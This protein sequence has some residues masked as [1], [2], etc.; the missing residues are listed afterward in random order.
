MWL[1]EAVYSQLIIHELYECY[2]K[3]FNKREPVRANVTVEQTGNAF[4]II[5]IET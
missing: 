5:S 2:K 4:R 1:G 3:L